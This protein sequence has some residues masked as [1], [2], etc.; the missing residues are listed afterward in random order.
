MAVACAMSG[1]YHASRIGT[2]EK[3]GLDLFGGPIRCDTPPMTNDIFQPT[4]R[5]RVRRRSQRGAYDRETVY[6]ILDAALVCQVGFVDEGRP[7]VIPTTFA[8]LGEVVMFHG[9]SRSRTL[10]A[11]VSGVDL[12][13]TVT[14]LDGLVLARS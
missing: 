1:P 4:E 6:P 10:L 14:L 12:C 13:F 3:C 2:I 11:A 5:T 7:V 9:A 8:R